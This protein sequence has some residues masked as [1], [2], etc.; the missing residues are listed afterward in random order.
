MLFIGCLTWR[1]HDNDNDND[2]NGNGKQQ[3]FDHCLVH[4]LTDHLSIEYLYVVVV[5]HGDDDVDDHLL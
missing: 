4:L 2:N 5:V 1:M 3:R